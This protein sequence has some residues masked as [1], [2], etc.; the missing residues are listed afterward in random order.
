MKDEQERFAA[1]REFVRFINQY[2]EV[3]EL[4]LTGTRRMMEDAVDQVMSGIQELSEEL[5]SK[6]KHAEKV[7][8]HTYLNPDQKTSEFVSSIQSSVDVVFEEA[9]G[10]LRQSM[11]QAGK[12]MEIQSQV[13][14]DRLRRFG[15]RFSKYMEALSTMDQEIGKIIYKMISALSN[16]DVIRQRLEHLLLSVHALKVGLSY[17]LIDFQERFSMQEV[18]LLKKD[19]LAY[20]YRLYTSEHEKDIY[21]SIFTAPEEGEQPKSS[22]DILKTS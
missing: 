14:E 12:E 13:V 16:D 18:S 7:L 17:V 1:S 20:T 19:L 9:R 6:S 5:E 11:D 8:E 15:G 2:T 22:S 21:E 3:I 10:Q 4:Q